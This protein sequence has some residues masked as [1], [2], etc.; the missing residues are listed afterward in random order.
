MS[1]TVESFIEAVQTVLGGLGLEDMPPFFVQQCKMQCLAQPANV[2]SALQL[3]AARVA[4]VYEPIAPF[5]R[6][7]THF[8]VRFRFPPVVLREAEEEEHDEVQPSIKDDKTEIANPKR[9]RPGE[10]KIESFV[11]A[12]FETYAEDDKQVWMEVSA[13]YPQL[14]RPLLVTDAERIVNNIRET[15]LFLT[16][17]C[18]RFLDQFDTA[19]PHH[20]NPS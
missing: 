2:E 10:K 6:P 16:D 20:D 14:E 11:A 7:P 9:G 3:L 13:A 15:H 5:E 18:K 17:K 1:A 19:T 4:N 12:R 8:G